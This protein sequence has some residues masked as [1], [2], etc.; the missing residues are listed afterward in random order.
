MYVNSLKIIFCI[1]FFLMYR[2]F[3]LCILL[4]RTVFGYWIFA[5]ALVNGTTNEVT[6]NFLLDGPLV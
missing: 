1:S 4:D 3:K 5:H 2:I 6:Q